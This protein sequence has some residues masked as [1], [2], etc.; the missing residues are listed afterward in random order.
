MPL[1]RFLQLAARRG[2]CGEISTSEAW[3]RRIRLADNRRSDPRPNKPTPRGYQ[4]AF[5]VQ[6][7]SAN[8]GASKYNNI[9]RGRLLPGQGRQ[10]GH[11]PAVL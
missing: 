4:C 5:D 11:A 10:V 6:V 2:L 9:P 7:A 1:R 8:I 3:A